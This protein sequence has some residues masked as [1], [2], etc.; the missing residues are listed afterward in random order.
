M[1]EGSI[2]RMP[3]SA[4][5]IGHPISLSGRFPRVARLRDEFYD[6]I[7]FPEQ[8]VTSLT[9]SRLPAD[10]FTFV[11]PIPARNTFYDFHREMNDA[12]VL[13]IASYEHWW[14]KQINDKTRNMI[15]KAAKSGVEVRPVAFSDDLVE[16]IVRIHNE[17]P[18]RQGRRFRHYGKPFNI[19]QQEHATFLQ[20]SEFFGAFFN[21]EMIGFIKLVHGTGVS[22][23]M[24]IVS[25]I[26][27][28]DKAPTNALIA[29]AVER[30]AEKGVPLL[31]YGS[32]SRRSMGDFKRHHAFERIEVPRFFVP[33]NFLG[34]MTI[35]LGL[36]RNIIDKFP[37]AWVDRAAAWRTRWNIGRL[38]PRKSHGAVAQLAE[39]HS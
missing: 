11:M 26:S 29:K 8:F 34:R 12:A 7:E 38:R 30:C 16:A 21:G 23:L 6:H 4:T 27:H 39:R 25:M 10:I 1:F 14:K 28:R 22:N 20:R 37:D 35:S 18:I 5:V 24:Q 15:R 17:S 36:H 13:K 31:H 33:L 19:V 2:S 3:T 32:W 9:L